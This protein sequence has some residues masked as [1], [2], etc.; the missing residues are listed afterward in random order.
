LVFFHCKSKEEG[1]TPSKV[2]YVNIRLLEVMRDDL[3]PGCVLSLPKKTLYCSHE[4]YT[5]YTIDSEIRVNLVERGQKDGCANEKTIDSLYECLSGSIES[6]WDTLDCVEEEIL[7]LIEDVHQEIKYFKSREILEVRVT[8]GLNLVEANELFI[9]FTSTN[10]NVS[11][12][13]Q[14][15][16]EAVL[17]SLMMYYLFK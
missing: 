3:K 14:L 13:A 16:L 4:V 10:F 2:E 17:A 7:K 9:S 1:D 11:K 12:V 15:D 6:T 8:I 5:G